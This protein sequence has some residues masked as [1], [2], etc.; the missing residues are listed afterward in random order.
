[1]MKIISIVFGI[2]TPFLFSKCTMEKHEVENSL[3]TI[4]IDYGVGNQRTIS[5][6][7][8]D[9]LTALEA[10]QHVATV[11]THPVGQY[12]FVATIDSVKGVCGYK[13]WY[14]TINGEPAKKLAINKIVSPADTI[15]WIYKTDVCSGKT[16]KLK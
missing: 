12:V 9:G 2:L 1:M 11:E 4:E 7:W 14:Y 16:E 15:S 10:L 13:V 5:T 6:E 8:E 3:L